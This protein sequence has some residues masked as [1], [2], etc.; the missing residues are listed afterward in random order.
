M[1]GFLAGRRL[2]RSA[3]VLGGAW[4]PRRAR[5]ASA[6][7][8]SRGGA[9]QARTGASVVSALPGCIPS[10]RWPG[11]RRRPSSFDRTSAEASSPSLFLG[12]GRAGLLPTALPGLLR[13]VSAARAA[14]HDER[15][16]ERPMPRIAKYCRAAAPHYA[17]EPRAGLVE[18]QPDLGDRRSGDQDTG[19]H[20][21]HRRPQLQPERQPRR[22]QFRALRTKCQ[23]HRQRGQSNEGRGH[24]ACTVPRVWRCR[25]STPTAGAG[26]TGSTGRR[27]PRDNV[28]CTAVAAARPIP[29]QSCGSPGLW[30][31]TAIRPLV[32][33][34]CGIG[35]R[36]GVN[37]TR[38]PGE[39]HEPLGESSV[40]NGNRPCR[41]SSRLAVRA[42]EAVYRAAYYTRDGPARRL[43]CELPQGPEGSKG[44][45]ALAGAR[46]P[47]K[48]AW[49]RFSPWAVTSY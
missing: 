28:R 13:A 43:S 12:R 18:V 5:R 26:R 16:V 14:A 27:L 30:S 8:A 40:G 21:R 32:G 10:V 36:E 39:R 38:V 1:R 22:R 4:P 25:L 44:Q 15:Q 11:P 31:G 6:G 35:T 34:G 49:C 48:G 42:A 3:T 45:W 24:Q 47:L 33:G 46:G 7:S 41:P 29:P 9:Q 20:V 17:E 19:Q 37:R 2:L 23:R